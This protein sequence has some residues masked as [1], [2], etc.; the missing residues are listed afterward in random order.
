MAKEKTSLKN[1]MICDICGFEKE[2]EFYS[3]TPAELQELLGWTVLVKGLMVAGQPITLQLDAHSKQCVMNAP[4]KFDQI[5][6]E[7]NREVLEQLRQSEGRL[8][9]IDLNSLRVQNEVKN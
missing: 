8:D 1:K 3:P 7:K 6:V 4:D 5:E 2:F 9:N